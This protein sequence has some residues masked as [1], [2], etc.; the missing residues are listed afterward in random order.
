MI[1]E[2]VEPHSCGI[3][4]EETRLNSRWIASHYEAQFRVDPNWKLDAFMGAVKR[5][6]NFEITK[7]M[8]YRAKYYAQKKV[9]GDEDKQ[10][11]RIRDYMQTL[12]NKNPG[13]V[14]I[15]TTEPNLE[16]HINPN[17]MFS[18]LFV[19]FHAQI[20]GFLSGRR[21]FIGLDGCFVK[22]ANGAQVLAA[23]ARDGNNNMFPLAFGVVNIEDTDNW[24]WFLQTLESAIGQGEQHGGWT[25]M[26]GR[27]K[28][29]TYFLSLSFIC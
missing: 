13:S 28:V 27:Q 26:S 20:Q 10:Y 7:R 14:A 18:G 15:V 29:I 6:F 3:N 1:R 16:P 24:T 17:P 12:L 9:L 21:P 2:D 23:S 5:D 8:A 4:R 25:I 19:S 22:L 11:L